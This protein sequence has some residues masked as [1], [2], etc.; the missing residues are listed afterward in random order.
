MD[1]KI[2]RQLISFTEQFQSATKTLIIPS[3]LSKHVIFLKLEIKT[4][5][6]AWSSKKL[7][8]KKRWFHSIFAPM[9]KC[10]DTQCF[11]PSR[12]N[13]FKLQTQ[14]LRCTIWI[15]CVNFIFN[16][17]LHKTFLTNFEKLYSVG[18][19]VLILQVSE[20]NY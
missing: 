8:W 6:I 5:K 17:R 4:S 13:P 19:I 12:R 15:F 14:F 3:Y 9:W 1:A 7:L 18:Y 10:I 11:N 2:L 20:N 16:F